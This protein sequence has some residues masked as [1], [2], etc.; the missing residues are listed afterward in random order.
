M[1]PRGRP[2]SGKLALS[3][4]NS[5]LIVKQKDNSHPVVF[6]KLPMGTADYAAKKILAHGQ[7]QNILFVHTKTGEPLGPP[8]F[9][10]PFTVEDILI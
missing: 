6:K 3:L 9:A 10:I 5:H 4:K 2:P 8:A 1:F 7:R